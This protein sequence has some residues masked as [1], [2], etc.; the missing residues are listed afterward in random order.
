MKTR[1]ILQAVKEQRPDVIAL[2]LLSATTYPTTKNMAR[3]IRAAAPSTPIIVGGVF[4][5]MH[6]VQ[7][8][9]DCESVDCVGVGEG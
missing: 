5:S 6:A 8:L 3:Q 9:R 1:H 2:S 4:A 7:I